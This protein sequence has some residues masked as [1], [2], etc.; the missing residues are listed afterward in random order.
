[1]FRATWLGFKFLLSLLLVAAVALLLSRPREVLREPAILGFAAFLLF[2]SALP[3]VSFDRPGRAFGLVGIVF[4]LAFLLVAG[5]FITGHTHLPKA[6][7]GRSAGLCEFINYL[8]SVG[9]P[10]LAGTPF[11]CLAVFMLYGSVVIIRRANAHSA[12]SSAA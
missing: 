12:A 7:G 8:H 10:Y 9:G 3:W 11:V 1:M 4:S 6:C 2:L 5:S